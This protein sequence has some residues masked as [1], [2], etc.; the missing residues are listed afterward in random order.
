MYQSTHKPVCMIA[1]HTIHIDKHIKVQYEHLCLSECVFKW[2]RKYVNTYI[3]HQSHFYISHKALY[4]D[5]VF[6]I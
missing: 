2:H 5:E 3:K 4:L 6:E 1:I